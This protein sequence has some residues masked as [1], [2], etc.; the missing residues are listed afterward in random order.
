[1]DVRWR[2]L[3]MVAVTPGCLEALRFSFAM[4]IISYPG[5]DQVAVT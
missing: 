2:V 3:M 5:V 1:M 4:R